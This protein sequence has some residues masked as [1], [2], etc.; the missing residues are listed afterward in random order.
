M[1]QLV[2]YRGNPITSASLNSDGR[3]GERI[4]AYSLPDGAVVSAM[5]SHALL[6]TIR[7]DTKLRE[8]L[9]T[10][11]RM[12]GRTTLAL[13]L[14]RPGNKEITPALEAALE[15]NMQFGEAIH[16]HRIRAEKLEESDRAY[17]N[18]KIAS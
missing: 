2:D 6:N 3:R 17:A 15:K 14:C 7:N 1:A 16:N 4:E 18:L 11:A 13:E 5:A 9:E 8:R 10:A 12:T